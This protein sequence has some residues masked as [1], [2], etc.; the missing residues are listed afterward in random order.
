MLATGAS[1]TGVM[2]RLAVVATGAAIPSLT[3]S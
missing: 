2:S 1:F 3:R